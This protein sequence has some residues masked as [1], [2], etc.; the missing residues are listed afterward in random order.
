MHTN[1]YRR[2]FDSVFGITTDSSH[3]TC[4]CRILSAVQRRQLQ[5]L[6]ILRHVQWQLVPP[7]K[8]VAHVT[9][10][11]HK[12]WSHRTRCHPWR[13]IASGGHKCHG[14]QTSE[15]QDGTWTCRYY[16]YSRLPEGYSHSSQSQTSIGQLGGHSS[17]H[18]RLVG[19][20]W[21]VSTVTILAP[22]DLRYIRQAYSLIDF[23][24]YI[25]CCDHGKLVHFTLVNTLSLSVLTYRAYTD[26][27]C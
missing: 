24:A 18:H 14:C 2:R 6:I 3:H 16:C 4:C 25:P 5:I 8:L 23:V 13:A 12:S 21:T 26:T 1:T 15:A 19:A 20:S 9:Q 22:S 7:D 11:R 27:P 10:P 17:Y